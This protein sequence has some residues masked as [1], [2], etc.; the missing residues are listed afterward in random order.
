MTIARRLALVVACL[1]LLALPAAARAADT[2]VHITDAPAF[3]PI[4]VS[5]TAGGSVTW[6]N[7]HSFTHDAAALDDTWKTP[8][9]DQGEEAT[10][11]F[12]TV[13]SFEYLCTLHPLM[14]GT[15]TVLPAPPDSSTAPAGSQDDSNGLV[16]IVAGVIG[17]LVAMRR[18]KT[19]PAR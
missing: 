9:L 5:V 8:Q 16:L 11:T 15:V 2:T 17:V 18:F 6:I 12:D 14:R 19:A 4:D 13:G 3:D 1:V 10:V 7:D